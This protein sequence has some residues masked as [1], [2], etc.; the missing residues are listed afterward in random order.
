MTMTEMEQRLATLEVEVQLIKEASS[1]PNKA[2]PKWVLA[3]AGRFQDDPGFDE[4]A[5]L[6]REYRESQRPG[7]KKSAGKKKSKPAVKNG[8]A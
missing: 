6:G 7:H 8:R 4:I 2:D 3:H 1:Q 5:R